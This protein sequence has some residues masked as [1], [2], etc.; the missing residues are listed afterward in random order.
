MGS[1]EPFGFDNDV[2]Q[3]LK[4]NI[5]GGITTHIYNTGLTIVKPRITVSGTATI[6]LNG[7]DETFTQGSYTDTKIAFAKGDNIIV[8]TG[9][10]RVQFSFS[11]EVLKFCSLLK[12]E[13]KQIRC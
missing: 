4:F 12:L 7:I 2:A 1:F 8:I 13:I 11:K 9:R 5:D 10:G 6:S 3:E